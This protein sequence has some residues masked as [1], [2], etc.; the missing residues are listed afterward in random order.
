MVREAKGM[1]L[2]S[3]RSGTSGTTRFIVLLMLAGA[4]AFGAWYVFRVGPSPE[5]SLV[6][7][8]PAVGR[9]NGVTALFSEPKLGL[10][11][12]RLELIQGGRT[13]ILAEEVFVPA[14]GIPFVGGAGR[15]QAV[16]EATIGSETLGWLE[17]GEV[18]LRAIAGRASGALRKP[19]PIT[20]ELTL[21]VRLRPP[22]LQVVS[23][24]HYARQGGSGAVVYRVGE[25]V[26]RSGVRA[27][28]VESPG[29]E[30][31][32]GG[33]DDRFSIYALPWNVAESA[34][35]RLFAEDDAGNRVEQPFL[36]LFKT[37][38]ARADVIRLSDAFLDRVVPAIASQTPGFDASGSLLEQYLRINGDLRRAE[39]AHVVELSAASRPEFLWS[40]AFLQM[41]NSARAAN[42]AE[43]RT[44]LYDGREVDQQ[45]HLG[46]DLA[47][48]ARAPVPAP[49]SGRVLF[50]GWMSLYG[51]AVIIDHGYGLLSLCGHMSTVDVATG[52]HVAKGDRLGTTGAT[53]LAGG[54]HLH[55][56]VFVHGQSVD[57]FEWFDAKWIRDNLATKLDVPMD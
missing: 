52:D 2:H 37:I 29:S 45:T 42:F 19:S 56:E 22:R 27:G 4:I 1:K 50:A 47:S 13:E 49:N 34:E 35:I 14:S 23:T 48:T 21:P 24:Q 51:N 30:L 16:L 38:P 36:D 41:P 43:T 17:E 55:L 46:L 11:A 7:E 8:R 54:D 33:P 12:V 44:Y 40:G 28:T 15:G 3:R 57:P 9:S 10:G 20:A 26:V 32:N 18:T 5:V 39:L 53:G 6:T 31:P 25:H